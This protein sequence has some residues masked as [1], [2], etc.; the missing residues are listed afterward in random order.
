MMPMTES[1]TTTID[2]ITS[3]SIDT[4]V[5][6]IVDQDIHNA[7][8]MLSKLN[9]TKKEIEHYLVKFV[10]NTREEAKKSLNNLTKNHEQTIDSVA[11]KKHYSAIINRCDE[12]LNDDKYIKS[13][14]Y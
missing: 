14:V 4:N 7:Y 10:Q 9:L 8:N 6:M 11:L 3:N 2:Y 5:V 13:I 1:T 12:V